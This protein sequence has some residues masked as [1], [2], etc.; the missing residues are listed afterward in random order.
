MTLFPNCAFRNPQYL[1]LRLL[2]WCICG[3]TCCKKLCFRWHGLPISHKYFFHS[4]NMQDA[5]VRETFLRLLLLTSLLADMFFYY[6]QNKSLSA[7][8][9]LVLII[10]TIAVNR[11]MPCMV[12]EVFHHRISLQCRYV[13]V[14]KR[15]K[16]QGVHKSDVLPLLSIIHL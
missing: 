13:S 11:N 3:C 16:C 15:W 4:I 7:K 14:V 8:M 5:S 12:V 9:D 2:N 6:S 1:D 10:L